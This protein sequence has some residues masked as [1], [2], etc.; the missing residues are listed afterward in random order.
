MSLWNLIAGDAEDVFHTQC[1]GRVIVDPFLTTDSAYC[2]KCDR[3]WTRDHIEE[4]EREYSQ[5]TRHFTLTD[6]A[7]SETMVYDHDGKKRFL[8]LVPSREAHKYEPANLLDL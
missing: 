1:N 4:I 2:V 3:E 6:Y 8:R 5:V 7:P